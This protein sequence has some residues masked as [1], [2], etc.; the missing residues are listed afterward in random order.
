MTLVC[1]CL[2]FDLEAL[3]FESRDL[4]SALRFDLVDE[5]T[6]VVRII[7]EVAR[8]VHSRLEEGCLF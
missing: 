2:L 1:R 3:Y 4:V 5:L 8:A 7:V 6:V